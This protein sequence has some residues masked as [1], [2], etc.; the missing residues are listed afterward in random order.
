MPKNDLEA[1]T[2]PDETDTTAQGTIAAST[3]RL[4]SIDAYRGLVMFLMIGEALHLGAI[5]VAH[6]DSPFWKFLAH[7]QEHVE[8][9]GCSLHDLIQPSFSFLVGVALPFSIAAR[10]SRGQ[11]GLRMSIHA[12]WRAFILVA[13]GIFLRSMDRRYNQTNFT[14]ED[15]LTQIGLGY[16]FLFLL[17]LRPVR[18]QWIALGLILVGY[19]AAFALYT[20][21]EG[22]DLTKVGVPADW[23]HLA[24]GF[25]A[26]WNKN[27]NLAWKFDT[28]FLNL[29]PRK[30]PFTYNG[31][32]YA[33]LSF[34][35]TLGTMILGLIA[36]GVLR[37]SE[38]P[39]PARIGWLVVAG[40]ICLAVGWGLG[41]VGVCPVV[42][43]IWT[44]SWVLFS[45]G[46]CFL[47]LAGWHVLVDLAGLWYLAFPLIVIG[48]NSIAAYIMSWTIKGFLNDSLDKHQWL[49]LDSPLG[50]WL[51]S[52]V[53][54][55]Y[56]PLIRGASVVL[57]IWLILLWMYRRKVFLRI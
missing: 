57:L 29:F 51:T 23:P 19:W 45:G 17:G 9:V 15:T 42:K 13:L 24:Q 32:G 2:D 21:G 30:Q 16:G 43:R 41:A 55:G 14:F 18:D 6:P 37:D 38:R 26:H 5:S 12:F 28:W 34:I 48:A 35:P 49:L 3:S 1:T 39:A 7:H 4:G 56:E 40:L 47:I 20:P 11:S 10:R 22:F 54:T 36:G 44:P 46:W 8:W 50:H 31:G 27:A 33:T 25:A 52:V 53:P